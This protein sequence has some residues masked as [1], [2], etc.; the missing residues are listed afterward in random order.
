MT[1]IFSVMFLKR[2]YKSRKS[3]RSNTNFSVLRAG[4]DWKQAF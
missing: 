2:T 1:E 4:A 3:L